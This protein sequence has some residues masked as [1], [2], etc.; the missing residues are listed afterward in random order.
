MFTF[1]VVLRP[2][3]IMAVRDGDSTVYS[4]SDAN[5]SQVAAVIVTCGCSGYSR[6]VLSLVLIGNYWNSA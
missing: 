2:E 6:G 4:A 5:E 3:T 1:S